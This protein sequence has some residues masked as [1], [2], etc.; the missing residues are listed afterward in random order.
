MPDITLL[1]P[2]A[3]ILGVTVTE[4]L[5]CRRMAPSEPMDT[6]AV[7]TLVNRAL[8][9]SDES[10]QKVHSKRGGYAAL[11]GVFLLIACAEAALFYALGY[12]MAQLVDGLLTIELLCIIFG[13]YF[14]LFAQEQI[15]TFYDQNRLNFYS[16]GVFRMNLPSVS[17]NNSNWPY[18][19]KTGRW[20]A[21]LTMAGYPLLYLAADK[22]APQLWHLLYLPV[23][24]LIL[25]GGLFIPMYVVAKKY[26]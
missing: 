9:L 21:L 3:G 17:F 8:T 1:M 26:Q 25:L 11:Y 23:T 6:D 2:L 4:L 19:L 7:E 15:P 14:C 12:S 13:G 20:W 18:I 24:L 22:L 5:E 10:R 16:D